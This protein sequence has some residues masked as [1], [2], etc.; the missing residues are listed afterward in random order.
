MQACNHI[1]DRVME[2][3]WISECPS[4]IQNLQSLVLRLLYQYTS[5]H[6][7][8]LMRIDWQSRGHFY[9][10]C[11]C[12]RVGHMIVCV[13]SYLDYFLQ[14]LAVSHPTVRIHFTI[15]NPIVVGATNP[16]DCVDRIDQSSINVQF[17]EKAMPT[18]SRYKNMP[19]RSWTG[20]T[21]YP[22]RE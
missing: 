18:I 5:Q 2:F 6:H 13:M 1:P 3:E 7:H 14:C 11:N 10:Y 17:L 4:N 8:W 20:I 15:E 21:N 9:F 22:C 19:I 16:N 12:H